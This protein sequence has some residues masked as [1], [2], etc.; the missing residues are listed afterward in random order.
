[1]VHNVLQTVIEGMLVVAYSFI[2]YIIIT[3]KLKTFEN[4]FY[5]M[6]VATG[7]A[8]VLSILTSCFQ[9][10]NRE[11]PLGPEYNWVV[12]AAMVI[13]GTTFLTH[14][15]GNMLITINRYSALCLIKIYDKV[16]YKNSN[17]ILC[18]ASSTESL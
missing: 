16:S 5:L 17:L 11:L 15:I 10:L 9:R 6:F 8:D 1:M 7:I 3:S 2:L 12:S 4:A 18:S 14:M 13:S